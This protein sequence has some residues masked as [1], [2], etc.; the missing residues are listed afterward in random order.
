MVEIKTREFRE[1]SDYVYMNFGINL[2]DKKKVLVMSRLQKVLNSHQFDSFESY[3]YNIK[4]DTSLKLASELI[5][6][7]STNHTYFMREEMHFKFLEDEIIPWI[8][9]NFKKRKDLRIWSAGCS[10]GQEPYTL[11]M[12]L[13]KYFENKGWDKRILAT[14]ISNRVLSLAKTGIYP[15]EQIEKLPKGWAK[16]FFKEKNQFTVEVKPFI[17][18]EVI[19]RRFNLMNPVFNFKKPLHVIFCRNVMIYFD[20]KTINQLVKRYYDALIPG[21]YL[22]TGQSEALNRDEIPFV[23]IKPSIYRKPLK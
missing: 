20:K 21:G 6:H 8:F 13:Y 19:F 9:N 16:R 5:D 11:A 12:V 23:Y 1:L 15:K 14:D 2:T 22:I 10:S 4:K 17:R 18:D 7:I 3:L